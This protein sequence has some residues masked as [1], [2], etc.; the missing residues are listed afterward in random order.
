ME[1]REPKRLRLSVP[2]GAIEEFCR[3]WK[4][5]ELSFFGSILRDDFGPDSDVD[6]LV[7]FGP[8]ARWGGFDLVEM[9]DELSALVGR[10]VDLLTRRSLEASKNWIRRKEILGSAEPF[11][12]SR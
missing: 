1:Q 7:A 5:D 10:P 8:D 12:V 2:R 4:I 11:F 6:V 9:R 3:R